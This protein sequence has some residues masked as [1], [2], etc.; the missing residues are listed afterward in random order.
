MPS[1]VP[2][3]MLVGSNA[4]CLCDSWQDECRNTR[5]YCHFLSLPFAFAYSDLHTPLPCVIFETVVDFVEF[6]LLW[7]LCT[8][9]CC[10][11]LYHRQ[12]GL[13]TL[14]FTQMC[15]RCVHNSGKQTR[16]L[17]IFS[18]ANRLLKY[19]ITAYDPIKFVNLSVKLG[20]IRY[21]W[22]DLN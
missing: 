12:G 15:R 4:V 3:T 22:N 13:T 7:Q 1:P 20:F 11:I 6:R 8:Y 21:R 17:S 5:N 16:H 10:T 19:I 9:A 2:R 18:Y 14:T